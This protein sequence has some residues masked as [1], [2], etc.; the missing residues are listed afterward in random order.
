MSAFA[1]LAERSSTLVNAI[2][3]YEQMYRAPPPSLNAIVPEF[4]PSI[5]VTGMGAHPKYEYL[6]GKA[7]FFDQNPWVL[8][9]FASTGFPDFDEFIYYPLQNYPEYRLC[10]RL[11]LIGDW[12]YIHE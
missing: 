11:E 3:A 5:P 4:I 7:D 9:V 12:A 8:I 10:N 6:V 1:A 2:R